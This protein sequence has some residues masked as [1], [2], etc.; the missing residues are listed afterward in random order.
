MNSFFTI[1]INNFLAEYVRRNPITNNPSLDQRLVIVAVSFISTYLI[2]VISQIKTYIVELYKPKFKY[3]DHENDNIA[4]IHIKC[5]GTLYTIINNYELKLPENLSIADK[6]SKKNKYNDKKIS[7]CIVPNA[8]DA[9]HP[10]NLLKVKALLPMDESIEKLNNS[11][12]KNLVRTRYICYNNYNIM[13]AVFSHVV[14][15]NNHYYYHF[16]VEKKLNDSIDDIYEVINKIFSEAYDYYLTEKSI[17][18]FD[19]FTLYEIRNKKWAD[20]QTL[21]PKSNVNIIG[22]V[23]RD[24]FADINLFQTE[25]ADMYKILDIPYKRG[26]LLY[27][28]PGCG[29]TSI[30]KSIASYTKK[31]IFKL[32]FNEEELGDDDYK[33]LFNE[34]P[35]NSIILIEDIDPNLLGEGGFIEK[36]SIKTT[37][38]GTNTETIT[39]KKRVSYNTLLDALDG[40][41][42]NTGRITFITTNHPNKI[43]SALLRPGRIDCKFKL[44]YASNEDIL[45]YFILYYNYFKLD[46]QIINDLA[47]TFIKQ[48]RNLDYGSKITIAELQQFLIQY[49]S[50]TDKMIANIKRF[51]Q[52]ETFESY[53]S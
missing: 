10:W 11:D 47:N 13:I 32:T 28:P 7:F 8:N 3:F 43:G 39:N 1:E 5:A 53:A 18:K 16:F 33:Q 19:K 24:I 34:T 50:N 26:Y 17:Q 15:G 38:N 30:I 40:I 46:T 52:N 51:K 37:N 29:K 2:V 12:I 45:E 27:G 14:N 4:H 44:D 20:I 23:S 31:N 36:S 6:F 42:S 35:F 21:N 22:Q 41:N 9:K 25:L 49:T 48:I